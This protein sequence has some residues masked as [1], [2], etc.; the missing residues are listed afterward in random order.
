[1][2]NLTTSEGKGSKFFQI[3]LV[4]DKI[5]EVERISPKTSSYYKTGWSPTIFTPTFQYFYRYIRHISVTF[6]NSGYC[7]P[8][9]IRM[10]ANILA[11][12]TNSF[13]LPRFWMRPNSCLVQIYWMPR[14]IGVKCIGIQDTY[15]GHTY[16]K[17]RHIGVTFRDLELSHLYVSLVLGSNTVVQDY[18]YLIWENG[19]FKPIKIYPIMLF[20]VESAQFA[21]C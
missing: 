1:M 16:W 17:P 5:T 14:H 13:R 18:S 4:K 11:V 9:V 12:K 19:V 7:Q 6:C 21:M 10:A 15:I 3:K 2:T 20:S 8:I